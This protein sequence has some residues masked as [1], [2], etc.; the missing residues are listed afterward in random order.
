M[1]KKFSRITIQF[2]TTKTGMKSRSS[3][4]QSTALPWL[5]YLMARTVFGKASGTH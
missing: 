4:Y 3:Y 1:L 2:S 5:T